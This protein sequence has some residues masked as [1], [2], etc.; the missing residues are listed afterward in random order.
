MKFHAI[1]F[2]ILATAGFSATVEATTR[3][4][5][6]DGCTYNQKKTSARNAIGS[7]IVYVF[8]A[9]AASVNKFR[10]YYDSLDDSVGRR[11]T[12]VVQRLDAETDIRTKYRQYINAYDDFAELNNEITLP[13]LFPVK[14]VAGVHLDEN[15][16]TSA[17]ESYL[18]NMNDFSEANLGLS[19]VI[20]LLLQ[21]NIPVFNMGH[22]MKSVSITFIFPDG[23]RMDFTIAF[24]LNA[25]TGESRPELTPNGNA[26]MADGR[27][28]PGHAVNVRD[29]RFDDTGGALHEWSNWVQELGIRLVNRDT[30]QN[31][32][33]MI[34]SVDKGVLRCVLYNSP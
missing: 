2:T 20:A 27:P 31:V 14:S 22:I 23:S 30:G 11:S 13:S 33:Y 8:D 12:K 7:G 5:S 15:Y 16:A 9:E 19:A 29:L 3:A 34:C 26:Y 21:K 6:C 17:L 1:I 32:P 4:T 10:V 28:F 24:S 18:M 25:G